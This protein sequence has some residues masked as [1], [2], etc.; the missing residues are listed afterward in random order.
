MIAVHLPEPQDVLIDSEIFKILY[1]HEVLASL[2]E[3]Y[4]DI[5]NAMF[6]VREAA[7][8]WDDV[9]ETKLFREHPLSGRSDKARAFPIGLHGDGAPVSAKGK[10]WQKSADFLSFSSLIGTGPHRL[11]HIIISAV[12]PLGSFRG[13]Y[14]FVGG[15]GGQD[16]QT[17]AHLAACRLQFLGESLEEKRQVM[18]QYWKHVAWSLHAC[19]LGIWPTE[20]LEG[21][22]LTNKTAGKPLAGGFFFVLWVLQ[23][24]LEFQHL[25]WGLPHWTNNLPC[26]RC[27]CRK[28]DLFNFKGPWVSNCYDKKTW[29]ARCK[30]AKV[31]AL[32]A[33]PGCWGGTVQPDLMHT[34]Y[35]GVDQYF[36]ASVIFV[37]DRV[38]QVHNWFQLLETYWK[39]RQV[40]S[41]FRSLKESMWAPKDRRD[42]TDSRQQAPVLGLGVSI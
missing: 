15:R 12:W 19:W 9:K 22:P 32:F 39:D 5:F 42:E 16:G 7:R 2:Y 13:V 20:D 11:L 10:T 31:C 34:K 35:L 33:L 29:N 40:T 36:L 24:D 26:N 38:K 6:D 1:P 41:H 27:G 3:N 21:T 30:A 17:N 4:R 37:L 28:E 23:A 8:F 18:Q 25:F 14:F